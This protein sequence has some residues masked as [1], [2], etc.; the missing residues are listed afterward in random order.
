MGGIVQDGVYVN[1]AGRPGGRS[2]ALT[3]KSPRKGSSMNRRLSCLGAL[4][5]LAVVFAL[6]LATCGVAAASASAALTSHGQL[7]HLA[8]GLQSNTN[9]SSN[10][11]GYNQG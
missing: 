11:F 9:S 10:W 5:R 8:P 2:A 3:R 4:Q 7:L 6:S 1:A